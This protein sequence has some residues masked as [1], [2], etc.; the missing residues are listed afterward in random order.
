[1][2]EKNFNFILLKK[3]F[4]RC[5]PIEQIVF[6]EKIDIEIQKKIVHDI[7]LDSEVQ[8]YPIK[9]VYQ[10]AFL[11]KLLKKLENDNQEICDELYDTFGNLISINDVSIT[12]YRHHLI[13]GNKNNEIASDRI[14]IEENKHI[15]S[16]GTTGLCSWQA[17]ELLAEWCIANRN[18]IKDK[19]L[20]E[21]G[22]GVGLTGITVIKTCSPKKYIFSDCHPTVL[23]L[24]KKNVELNLL[25]S[26]KRNN[27]ERL[28]ECNTD[29]EVIDLAWE[30]ID[31]LIDEEVEWTPPHLI[32]A[33]DVIYDSS[34]FY[35]LIK[36]L[37]VLLNQ[38][39]SYAIIGITVRNDATLSTFLTQL[40]ESN[41]KYIE[42]KLPNY[43]TFFKPDMP[44]KLVK[45]FN[46]R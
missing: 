41:L 5:C 19:N 14:I 2:G 10:Q 28:Y 12:H 43:T 4:L 22:S 21:L 33:A 35:S 6:P 24:L 13:N 23:T 1:M 38:V 30:S 39:N 7:I 15:I 40:V 37:K 16:Q 26:M 9:I 27:K 32:L 44:L 45:I 8:K 34:I 3:Q 25:P 18:E 17:A 36:A 42:E 20:L 31:K 11:R 46:N 29:V